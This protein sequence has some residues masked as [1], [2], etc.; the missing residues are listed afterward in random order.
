[1]KVICEYC[2]KELD[3]DHVKDEEIQTIEVTP[4]SDCLDRVYKDGYEEA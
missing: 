1:M 4:C 3:W 2:K